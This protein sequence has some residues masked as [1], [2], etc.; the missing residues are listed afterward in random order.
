[1]VEGLPSSILPPPK[2]DESTQ[3]LK[4]ITNS[5]LNVA[6]FKARYLGSVTVDSPRGDDTITNAA[7][8]V[9]K[10]TREAID[11]TLQITATV[12]KLIGVEML[13]VLQTSPLTS[14]SYCGVDPTNQ[15]LFI[16][17]S[18]ANGDLLY[19]HVLATD[20]ACAIAWAFHDAFEAMHSQS[21]EQFC[22][23]VH[24]SPVLIKQDRQIFEVIFLGVEMVSET[25]GNVVVQKA[26]EKNKERLKLV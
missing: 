12:I 17:I 15:N 5:T 9:K 3:P 2:I 18:K 21:T 10:M 24:L 25:K 14:I 4:E 8:R 11:V 26:V 23:E 7:N 20:K 22:G 16:Y 1:M 19:A 13:D 6:G